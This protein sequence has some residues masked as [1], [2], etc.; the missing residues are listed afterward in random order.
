[1]SSILEISVNLSDRDLDFG[2]INFSLDGFHLNLSKEIGNY[3]PNSISLSLAFQETTKVYIPGNLML[4]FHEINAQNRIPER[5][6]YMMRHRHHPDIIFIVQHDFSESKTDEKPRVIIECKYYNCNAL[7]NYIWDYLLESV[8]LKSLMERMLSGL[9]QIMFFEY[10]PYGRGHS[11]KG[12]EVI[13][14]V[15]IW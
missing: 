14:Q 2:N 6:L 12:S 1:M 15:Y 11:F 9:K 10:L 5:G 8:A 4:L 7:N 3:V 13:E